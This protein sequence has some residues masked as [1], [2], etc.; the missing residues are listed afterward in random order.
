MIK[1]YK[2]FMIIPPGE[3]IKEEMEER[4][5]DQYDLSQVLGVSPKTVSKLINN[6]QAITIETARLLGKAFGQSPDYWI[7]LQNNY[8]LHKLEKTGEETDVEQRALIYSYMPVN[9]LYRK[10]WIKSIKPV[11]A[12]ENEI[13][14]FFRM[15]NLDFSIFEQICLPAF[16]K[17]EAYN[18]YNEYHAF[19][20]FQMAKN[21]AEYYKVNNYKSENLEKLAGELYRYTV[22]PEGVEKFIEALNDSGVK[23]FILDHLPETYIDGASFFHNENPVIVYTKRLDRIDNFWFL[24]SHEIAH[25]LK[26]LK[27]PDDFFIDID[28]EQDDRQR[29]QEIEADEFAIQVI[30]E[31][32]IIRYCRPYTYKSHRLISDCERELKINS[33]II[34]GVL[35]HRGM[36]SRKNLNRYKYKVSGLVPEKYFMKNLKQ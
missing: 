10:G 35:Q 32:E 9:E 19:A 1:K 31:K 11:S 5:W 3:F 21:C 36:V 25:I 15:D 4:N 2:P 27:G 18:K 13:K 34:V 16:R 12:L 24:V 6:K 30:K 23:F 7:N 29:Q 20:W 33:G 8:L 14:K 26:H 28:S 17:S 22:I